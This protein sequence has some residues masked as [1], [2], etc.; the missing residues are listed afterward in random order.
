MTLFSHFMLIVYLE[1]PIALFSALLMYLFLGMDSYK[2]AV[3]TGVVLALAFFTKQTGLFLIAGILVYEA[4]YYFYK[5]DKNQLKF[6][7][8]S[9]LIAAVLISPFLV[10]NITLY[11][12]PFIHF[13]NTL[14]K[15]IDTN[16]G[17]EGV[18]TK[19]LSVPMFTV[20]SYANNIGWLAVIAMVLTLVWFFLKAGSKQ[21]SKE[22]LVSVIFTFIF[23]VLYY[24]FYLTD[25][26]ISE[27]RNLF[28]IFPQFALIGGFFLWKLSTKKS[29]FKVLLLL[30]IA[31][32]AYTSIT[33]AAGTA[34]SQ[35]Y[36]DTY[37]SAL[38]WVG[39]NTNQNDIILTTYG[40]S[41]KYFADR[42][43]IW[44][45]VKELPQ[46][47]STTDSNYTYDIMKKY[48]VSY[49]LIWRGVLNENFIIPESNLIGVFTV[50][51]LN[52]VLSDTEHFNVTYQNQ[53]DIV[54]K[55]L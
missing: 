8:V 24:I 27:P 42:D 47:M 36:P 46:I 34:A 17:W 2:K 5:R 12:Y 38:E 10:R 40:G 29:Y 28:V 15:F 25:F 11:N 55:V 54:F 21:V 1:V 22:L 49:I 43:N 37:V 26:G 23:M 14:F 20:Q 4:I 35:R 9:I 51:F 16:L 53:D 3:V 30:V 52:T 31:L 44:D 13:A 48:N 6:T 41:L 33:I 50:N 32:S 45:G 18:T 7:F 19:L 39:K